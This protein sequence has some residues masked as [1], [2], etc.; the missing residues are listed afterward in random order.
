MDLNRFMRIR[1][2]LA[3]GGTAAD[4]AFLGMFAVAFG[5]TLEPVQ[6][7]AWFGVMI[8]DGTGFGRS[9]QGGAATA[10]LLGEASRR[11][12]PGQVAPLA[13]LAGR[14]AGPP[15]GGSVGAT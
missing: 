7:A 8:V 6:P 13:V 9:N 3:R 1:T 5:L 4:A 12:R 2:V 10:G 11:A 15:S 14:C